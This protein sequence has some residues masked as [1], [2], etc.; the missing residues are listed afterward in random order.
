MTN[1]K[2]FQLFFCVVDIIRETPF[3]DDGKK[4][5][6]RSTCVISLTRTSR[7]IIGN[8]LCTCKLAMRLE[9]R[10][11]YRFKLAGKLFGA[12]KSIMSLSEE[13]GS[14][15][16]PADDG[17]RPPEGGEGSI[18][19]PADDG[20]RPPEGG[21]T[22]H[23]DPKNKT[24]KGNGG[25][26]RRSKSVREGS[27]SSKKENS[28]RNSQR[29]HDSER[30]NEGDRNRLRETSYEERRGRGRKQNAGRKQRNFNRG[31]GRTHIGKK[32][33]IINPRGPIKF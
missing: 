23:I 27:S 26:D 14:F 1:N 32:V 12:L 13:N 10:S 25:K 18:Q 5:D 4:A 6:A 29:G 21:E 17:K 11:S 19:P 20:K 31:N 2:I 3:L 8:S 24:D 7:G 22:A 30:R 28:R 33:I 16:P 15:Q 9:N